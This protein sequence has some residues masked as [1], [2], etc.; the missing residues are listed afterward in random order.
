MDPKSKNYGFR[1][2]LSPKGYFKDIENDFE[3]ERIYFSVKGGIFTVGYDDKTQEERAKELTEATIREWEFRNDKKIDYDLD[4]QRWKPKDGN[5]LIH[6]RTLKMKASTSDRLI[7][8]TTKKVL[9]IIY[10]IISDSHDF[11]VDG[12][13]IMIIANNE[14]LKKVLKIYKDEVLSP[15]IQGKAYYGIYKILEELKCNIGG[16][17]KL[18]EITGISKTKLEKIKQSAQPQR[19]ARTSARETISIHESKRI[20]RELIDKYISYL[21]E[22]I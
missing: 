13:K 12:I 10:T 11:N 19:H 2:T 15:G 22:K 14:S 16:L 21:V 1:V 5:A 20:T 17:D 4:E 8:T 18:S 7:I 9:G 3:I 6:A